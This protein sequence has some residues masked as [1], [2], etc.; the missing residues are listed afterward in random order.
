MMSLKDQIK[1]ICVAGMLGIASLSGTAQAQPLDTLKVEY[2][3]TETVPENFRDTV[4]VALD[5]SEEWM[6]IRG[7][8]VK[9]KK[10]GES[11]TLL[12]IQDVGTFSKEL[13]GKGESTDE[14][15]RFNEVRAKNESGD[16]PSVYDRYVEKIFSRFEHPD[17]LENPLYSTED[18]VMLSEDSLEKAKR[19]INRRLGYYEIRDGNHTNVINLSANISWYHGA[20]YKRVIKKQMLSDNPRKEPVDLAET[21]A[22]T[23]SHE[24]LHTLGIKD[25]DMLPDQEDNEYYCMIDRGQEINVMDYRQRLM[26]EDHEIL[27]VIATPQQLETA[28]KT[29]TPGTR[30]NDAFEAGKNMAKQSNIKE[31]FDPDT[32]LCKPYM[33]NISLTV[34]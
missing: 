24:I 19:V 34:D 9:Y 15:R 27:G 16:I 10:N 18:D 3:M 25:L 21:I 7:V 13:L 32:Y 11:N 6:R 4:D 17:E 31:P 1:N 29:L 5:K 8:P 22:R 20:N 23:I 26:K 33:R 2:D 30:L 28:K 12:K 14:M